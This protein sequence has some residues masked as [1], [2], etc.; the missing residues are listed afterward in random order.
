MTSLDSLSSILSIRSYRNFEYSDGLDCHNKPFYK[1]KSTFIFSYSR[2][3]SFSSFV[4]RFIMGKKLTRSRPRSNA[5]VDKDFINLG[6]L[7]Q[8]ESETN[9][10][11]GVDIE[12]YRSSCD[13]PSCTIFRVPKSFLRSYYLSSIWICFYEFSFP[14]GLSFPF[15]PL[16]SDLFEVTELLMLKLC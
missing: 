15:P 7:P 8:D 13:F 16:I 4:L 5:L 10:F 3:G 14:I 9:T 11:C 6:M 1:S 2:K 12:L